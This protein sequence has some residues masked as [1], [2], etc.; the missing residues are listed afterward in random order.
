MRGGSGGPRGGGGCIQEECAHLKRIAKYGMKRT[1]KT[2]NET[3][4][5][6]CVCVCVCGVRECTR[7]R[8]CAC[9]FV[10]VCAFVCARKRGWAC[11]LCECVCECVCG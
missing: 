11:L 9:A 2:M 4:A 3:P 7:A 1:K 5:A 10:F 6:T 8:V